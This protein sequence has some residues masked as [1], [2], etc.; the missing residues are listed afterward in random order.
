MKRSP[1]CEPIYTQ[2]LLELHKM[3]ISS[4]D[5]QPNNTCSKVQIIQHFTTHF[6]PTF[7]DL[8]L[9]KST[10]S[11]RKQED[12]ILNCSENSIIN[13]F[14]VSSSPWF[15]CVTVIPTFRTVLYGNYKEMCGRMAWSNC[16]R[17]CAAVTL[18]A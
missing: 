3:V 14:W 18:H 16:W 8:L 7:Y 13:L 2:L 5:D 4:L 1:H 12:T 10:V 9:H 15:W 17:P 6:S 11:L